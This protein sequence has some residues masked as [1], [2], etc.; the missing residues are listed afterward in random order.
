MNPGRKVFPSAA[1]FPSNSKFILIFG[2]QKEAHTVSCA[3]QEA[4][5]SQPSPIEPVRSISG[6]NYQYFINV[7]LFFNKNKSI[8]NCFILLHGKSE[9]LSNMLKI[10][11][12]FSEG[13][14]F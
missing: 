10:H 11:S 9:A 3:D 13:N 8:Q 14:F 6:S 1:N 4:A 2:S 12:D 7:L 5:H